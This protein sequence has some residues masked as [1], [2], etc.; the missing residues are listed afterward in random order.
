LFKLVDVLVLS[1]L[2]F[3]VVDLTGDPHTQGIF[4]KIHDQPTPILRFD[5][6]PAGV[7]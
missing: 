5:K 6:A 2:D 7:G 1:T 3:G 4:G